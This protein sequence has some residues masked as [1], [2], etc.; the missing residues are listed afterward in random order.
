MNFEKS[1]S[2]RYQTRAKVL[3]HAIP[4][5]PFTT[6]YGDGKPEAKCDMDEE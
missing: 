6:L 5:R 3:P 1:A 4:R 2:K